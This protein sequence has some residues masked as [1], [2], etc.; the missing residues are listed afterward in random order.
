MW[1][2]IKVPKPLRLVVTDGIPITVHSATEKRSGRVGVAMI[3]KWAWQ[4]GRGKVGVVRWAW[5]MS[6]GNGM[7][8]SGYLVCIPRAHSRKGKPLNGTPSQIHCS[9][10][11]RVD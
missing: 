10:L 2:D 3:S 1:R 4:G 5:C 11:Q 6:A 9:P 7:A 8:V